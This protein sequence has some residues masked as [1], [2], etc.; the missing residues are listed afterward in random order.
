MGADDV[1]LGV[2]GAVRVEGQLALFLALLISLLAEQA[3]ETRREVRG[4]AV[5]G[6]LGVADVHVR[7]AQF[8]NLFLHG[9]ANGMGQARGLLHAS[10]QQIAHHQ[11]SGEA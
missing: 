9:P 2:E 4:Q 11:N 7:E 1:E 6:G 5:D 3:V 10:D 8:A